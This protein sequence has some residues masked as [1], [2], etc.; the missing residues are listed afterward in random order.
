MI[1]PLAIAD[2]RDVIHQM[3]SMMREGA[4][5]VNR[6]EHGRAKSRM[7]IFAMLAISVALAGCGEQ[8]ADTT[9]A[10]TTGNEDWDA[11]VQTAHEEGEVIVYNTSSELQNAR[12]AEAWSEEYPGITLSIVRGA[13]ELPERVSTELSSGSNGADVL[14][15][16]DPSWFDANEAALASLE[17]VPSV[18]GWRE[19]W[20]YMPGKAVLSTALPYSMI[21]WNVD[22]FP[23]GFSDWDDLLEPSVKGRLGLRSDVTPSIAAYL[24]FFESEL[25]PEYLEDLG[26][27]EPKYYPSVLPLL[28]AVASGEVGVANIGTPS[29]F[30]DLHASGAPI[31]FAYAEPGFAIIH[32]AAAF[33][34]SRRPNA[35]LVFMD[36]LMSETGQEAHNGDGQG[37]AGR[38]GIDGAL[39]MDNY[40]MFDPVE[41][42]RPEV[43]AEWDQKFDHYFN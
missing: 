43:L 42:G 16:S 41:F 36:F 8:T 5:S 2:L 27:Q 23:E 18:E 7:P 22:T 39:S 30:Q 34:E 19:D 35:G 17:N 28:Q 32:A 21:V 6:R 20:W 15:F 29:M 1:V 38:E 4:R 24:D 26:S 12:I 40:I 11:I 25:G 31:D 33:S 13:G 10:P 9:V 3:H 37:A 14:M